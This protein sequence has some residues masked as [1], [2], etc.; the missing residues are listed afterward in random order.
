MNMMD[1]PNTVQTPKTMADSF[2]KVGEMR[3]VL[4]QIKNVWVMSA[5]QRMMVVSIRYVNERCLA[6]RATIMA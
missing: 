6:R 4:R 2:I 1:E 5:A 3:F